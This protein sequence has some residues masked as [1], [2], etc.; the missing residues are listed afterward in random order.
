MAE[1]AAARKS[2][3]YTNLGS[4][5]TFQPVAIETLGPINDT[6]R[7][8]LSNLGHKISLQSGDDR[9]AMLFVSAN[10]CSDPAVQCT[11]TT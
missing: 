3:K 2:A 7:D 4:H 9:E 5:Y 1:L 8:F 10:L 6:A 11:F